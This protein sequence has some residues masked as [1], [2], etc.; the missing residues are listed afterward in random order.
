MAGP[1]PTVSG[2]NTPSKPNPASVSGPDTTLNSSSE[3]PST[4][5]LNRETIVK[6]DTSS[7]SAPKMEESP[8]IV[9]MRQAGA[10]VAKKAGERKTSKTVTQ[11]LSRDQEATAAPIAVVET[12]IAELVED[13]GALAEATAA[14][15]PEKL[16]EEGAK[17]TSVDK[18]AEE[19]AKRTSMGKE[20]ES[21]GTGE[22][23]HVGLS[24]EATLL[25]ARRA[26]S[27]TKMKTPLSEETAA[28]PEDE[29]EDT[30]KRNTISEEVEDL[31]EPRTEA[32]ARATE[33]A[34]TSVPGNGGQSNTAEARMEKVTASDEAED[35]A[36]KGVKPQEQDAKDAQSVGLSL[37]D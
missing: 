10:E 15:V 6:L 12:K 29:V 34:L 37:G 32:E 26:S 24:K 33:T 31:D 1:T 25:D 30:G 23:E 9:A 2:T 7:M 14:K 35:A 36:M 19:G 28:P 8:L 3:I 17:R 13:P 20:T 21:H 16:A 11:A 5:S 22:Q 4:Q 18:I 27:I